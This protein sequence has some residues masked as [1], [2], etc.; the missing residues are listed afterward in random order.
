MD[1]TDGPS[2]KAPQLSAQWITWLY[3]FATLAI[4]NVAIVLLAV[5]TLELLHSGV[6]FGMLLLLFDMVLIVV[7][8]IF[9]AIRDT[10]KRISHLLLPYI[11]IVCASNVPAI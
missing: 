7:Y 3:T 11:R 1:G 2:L 10:C 6:D 9:V 4:V 8:F 5:H